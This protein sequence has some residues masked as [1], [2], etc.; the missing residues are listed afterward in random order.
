MERALLTLFSDSF[1]ILSGSRSFIS[2]LGGT[3]TNFPRFYAGVEISIVDPNAQAAGVDRRCRGERPKTNA[4]S[5][6]PVE[7]GL[8]PYTQKRVTF[9][10]KLRRISAQCRCCNF[11]FSSVEAYVRT[12]YEPVL[13]HH[14]CLRC[15]GLGS[16][17]KAYKFLRATDR[18]TP[19]STPANAPGG[20]AVVRPARIRDPQ[21]PTAPTPTL[22][23]PPTA[24]PTASSHPSIG[25]ELINFN[26][27]RPWR[28]PLPK[29]PICLDTRALPR[30]PSYSQRFPTLSLSGV[31]AAGY[32]CD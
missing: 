12:L 30:E 16:I 6:Q 3:R 5:R 14:F 2:R 25:T 22:T 10:A 8:A 15:I 9:S 20:Q 11:R 27:A 19:S 24:A 7:D 23:Q 32:S 21:P 13:H 1:S 28:S 18:R 31:D 29:G 4:R 17:F 26:R